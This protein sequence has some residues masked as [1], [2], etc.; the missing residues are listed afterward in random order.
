MRMPFVKRHLSAGKLEDL[1]RNEKEESFRATYLHQKPI[2]QRKRSKGSWK[3]WKKQSSHL[4]VAQKIQRRWHRKN[5]PTFRGGRP[6]KLSSDKQAAKRE[7]QERRDW[8]TKEVNHIVEEEF[9]VAYSLRSIRRILRLLKMGYAKPYP[10]DYRRP[11]TLKL[12]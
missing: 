11:P 7:T 6:P 8:T 12:I 10:R 9:K 4:R 5:R 3:T 1:I 2:R